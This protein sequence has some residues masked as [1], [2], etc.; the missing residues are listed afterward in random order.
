MKQEIVKMELKETKLEWNRNENKEMDM[1][2]IWRFGF[3]NNSNDMDRDRYDPEKNNAQ[4]HI[5][6]VSKPV[7]MVSKWEEVGKV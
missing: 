7:K 4:V 3:R 5:L 1:H 6:W 2:T